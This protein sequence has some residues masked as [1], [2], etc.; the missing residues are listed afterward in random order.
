MIEDIISALMRIDN[1]VFD[2]SV[3]TAQP[4]YLFDG[5]IGVML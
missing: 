3:N 5:G 2:L 4:L 1:L